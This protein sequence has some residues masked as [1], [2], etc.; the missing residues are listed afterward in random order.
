MTKRLISVYI[1]IILNTFLFQN[2]SF[3]QIWSP[4]GAEWYYDYIN[5]WITGYVKITYIGDTVISDNSNPSQTHNC[6]ILSKTFYSFNHLNYLLDTTELGYEYT[7]SNNDT[8]F[9]FRNGNFYVLYDFSANINDTWIIPQTYEAFCDTIGTIRVTSVGDTLINGEELRFINVEPED[10]SEWVIQGL[11][12]EKLGPINHYMLPEQNCIAD[13]FEGGPLRC[14]N[15]DNFEFTTGVSSYCDFI[16][17]LQESNNDSLNVYPN[18]ADGQIT[19]S[20]SYVGQYILELKNLIGTTFWKYTGNNKK[21][22]IETKNIPTGI[23]I[24]TLSNKK[25]NIYFSKLQIIK[26]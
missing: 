4:S 15:D 23:Y 8:V 11:I 12:I 20:Y 18:P 16:V 2:K 26:H 5:A 13:L 17:S 25:S 24:I 1:L 14:Y 6:R 22:R 21:L 3:A 9:L 7:Y 10:Q 19:L